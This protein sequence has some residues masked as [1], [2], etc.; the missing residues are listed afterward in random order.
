L[1]TISAASSG[2]ADY[3]VTKNVALTF[4]E[5]LYHTYTPRGIGVSCFCPLGIKTDLMSRVVNREGWDERA[6]AAAI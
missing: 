6:W 3:T 4:N 1:T 2:E 5:W